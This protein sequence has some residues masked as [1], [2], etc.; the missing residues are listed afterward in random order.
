MKFVQIND[1]TATISVEGSFRLVQVL[2]VSAEL[3][4]AYNKGI[5]KVIADFSKTSYIDS[6]A[7]TELIKALRKVGPDN[8]SIL[9]ANAKVAAVLRGANL[10]QWVKG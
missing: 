4:E 9:N 2:S 10:M 7:V 6:S 1:D 3:T 5:S 8:F